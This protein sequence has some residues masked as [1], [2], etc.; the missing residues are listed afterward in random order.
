MA[1]GLHLSYSQRIFPAVVRRISAR[2]VLAAESAAP[3]PLS[4]A[5]AEDVSHRRACPLCLAACALCTARS[6]A[7]CEVPPLVQVP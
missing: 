1:S 3:F 7:I 2:I 6:L 5:I 4:R